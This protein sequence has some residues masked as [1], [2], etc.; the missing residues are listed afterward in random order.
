MQAVGNN[1]NEVR[2]ERADPT[3]EEKFSSTYD[4]GTTNPAALAKKV[5]AITSKFR[6]HALDLQVIQDDIQWRRANNLSFDDY[7]RRLAIIQAALETQTDTLTCE[8]GLA[9]QLLGIQEDTALSKLLRKVEKLLFMIEMTQAEARKCMALSESGGFRHAYAHLQEVESKLIE[10]TKEGSS[11]IILVTE[12]FDETIRIFVERA[13]PELSE[14]FSQFDQC[15]RNPELSV[16]AKEKTLDEFIKRRV[17]DQKEN[18]I[19]KDQ[20]NISLDEGAQTEKIKTKA[21]QKLLKKALQIAAT[22]AA[23]VVKK[24]GEVEQLNLRVQLF[25]ALVPQP[26]RNVV[27]EMQNF[28]QIEYDASYDFWGKL[29]LTIKT[30]YMTPIWGGYR[31][32]VPLGL[33]MA[34]NVGQP[35]ASLQKKFRERLLD[36]CRGNLEPIPEN[37]T[38]KQMIDSHETDLM[39]LKKIFAGY[40]QQVCQ[41]Q[42]DAITE[43][44]FDYL[45]ALA[46]AFETAESLC[47]K[48]KRC[49]NK[50]SLATFKALN[51]LAEHVQ[52]FD[53]HRNELTSIIALFSAQ[54]QWKEAKSLQPLDSSEK[55]LHC[56]HKESLHILRGIHAKRD[57][58]ILKLS[59]EETGAAESFLEERLEC[60]TKL[61]EDLVLFIAKRMIHFLSL[62]ADP[63][64]LVLELVLYKLRKNKHLHELYLKSLNQ[65]GLGNLEQDYENSCRSTRLDA[66]KR[67]ELLARIAYHAL[68]SKRGNLG[69]V[70]Y[71][72][73]WQKMFEF[74][75]QTS[76][77]TVDTFRILF[78]KWM[79]ESAKQ[80]HY[81]RLYP[82]VEKVW[83]FALALPKFLSFINQIANGA[84]KLKISMPDVSIEERQQHVFE[85]LLLKLL[86]A[87]IHAVSRLDKSEAQSELNF[88]LTSDQFQKLVAQLSPAVKT[89]ISQNTVK[90]LLVFSLK[91]NHQPV[92]APLEWRLLHA[93]PFE[94]FFTTPTKDF[95]RIDVQMVLFK[96]IGQEKMK[97]K[98]ERT[99][100]KRFE[101]TKRNEFEQWCGDFEK[102]I[103]IHAKK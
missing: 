85:S 28:E 38:L 60:K 47:R 76:S 21:V 54:K 18:S 102:L 92:V 78:D 101:E 100:T 14:S 49:A 73:A 91:D 80:N 9:E 52:T 42:P 55:P 27:L 84:E 65:N 90:K 40:H 24:G 74:S 36:F 2:V 72:S 75:K 93:G 31:N 71:A 19:P 41:L 69:I 8:R 89:L 5:A 15:F 43:K 86:C 17:I 6:A 33:E 103:R 12:I 59:D 63:Q 20:S 44:L 1:N 56:F 50:R 46:C 7:T 97:V 61:P 68:I 26:V 67:L 66:E 62:P 88:V 45:E 25:Q 23:Q 77:G 94:E 22:F 53:R 51:A 29:D 83:D 3:K 57:E 81:P 37:V 64:D 98:E 95:K 79:D 48:A 10:A 34:N 32:T 87:C 11:T 35:L 70:N 4:G 16:E 39:N 96:L 30:S 58:K 82:F 13:K 99:L